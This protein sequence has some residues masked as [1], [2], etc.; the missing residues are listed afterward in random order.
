MD[1]K[2]DSIAYQAAKQAIDKPETRIVFAVGKDTVLRLAVVYHLLYFLGPDIKVRVTSKHLSTTVVVPSTKRVF[3]VTNKLRSQQ[4]PKTL[5]IR[6]NDDRP[7]E[8][9]KEES[10]L[11]TLY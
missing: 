2:T 4:K 6:V 9:E 7:C 5:V 8:C 10:V 3:V 1:A 11:E